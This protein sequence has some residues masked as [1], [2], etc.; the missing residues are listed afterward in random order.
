MNDGEYRDRE[1][2]GDDQEIQSS[3]SESVERERFTSSNSS[4][5]NSRLTHASPM[6]G[7]LKLIYVLCA[8][9]LFS[10]IAM[11]RERTRIP[12]SHEFDRAGYP[13]NSATSNLSSPDMQ[14]K[15][16]WTILIMPPGKELLDPIIE[17]W[18]QGNQ[19]TPE[20]IA[21]QP[22]D[23]TLLKNCSCWTVQPELWEFRKHVPLNACCDRMYLRGHKMGVQLSSLLFRAFPIHNRYQPLNLEHWSYN[24][25]SDWRVA[26]VLRNIYEALVSGYLYHKEG[27]ECYTDPNGVVLRDKQTHERRVGQTD[28]LKYTTF[29]NDTLSGNQTVAGNLCQYL[30]DEPVKQGMRAYIDFVFRGDYYRS[31]LLAWTALSQQLDWIRNITH[32]VCF[33]E[34]MK[35]QSAALTDLLQFYFPSGTPQI[36]KARIAAVSNSV[37]SG[38]K[39][40]STY[41]GPHATIHDQSVREQLIQV[42]RELDKD[43]YNGQIAFVDSMIPCGK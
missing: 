35:N 21:I 10:V 8:F 30:M 15:V 29:I 5:R 43:Y 31:S 33:E 16:S 20:S 3:T 17:R 41:E 36:A 22:P 42:I 26:L 9:F 23:P 13:Q 25:A 14:H 18:R 34:L 24:T 7:G 12:W 4:S 2:D 11:F 19:V 6:D 39:R 28:Y 1:T 32:I 27:R 38:G 37:M 40:G